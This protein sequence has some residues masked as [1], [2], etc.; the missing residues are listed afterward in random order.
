M[1]DTSTTDTPQR[2]HAAQAAVLEPDPVVVTGVIGCY[3]N[4]LNGA[5]SCEDGIQHNG[6]PLFRKILRKNNKDDCLRFQSIDR[7]GFC[8][9][10][11]LNS[12]KLVSVSAGRE[13]HCGLPQ[14]VTTWQVYNTQLDSPK[15]QT[16]PA[17]NSVSVSC[18][19]TPRGASPA[20]L[21][22]VNV[23]HSQQFDM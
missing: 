11:S 12:D 14:D 3:V 1:D 16:Q 21:E 15:L 6:K 17:S 13:V 4:R 22:D 8:T 5:Y 10:K 23:I 9:Y 19:Q 2:A 7:W 18:P 20:Q